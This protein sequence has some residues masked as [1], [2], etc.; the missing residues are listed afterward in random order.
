M[1]FDFVVLG[2][3][4]EEG[5]IASRDLLKSGYSVLLCGRNKLR[6]YSLLK[7]RHSRFVYVDLS[8]I[9]NTV[10]VLKDS[11]AK[12][13]LN[14]AELRWNLNAMQA[15]LKANMH[16]LDLGGL[17]EITK[18]Q[19]RL[20]SKFR[21]KNLL[22]LLGCG[23]TPGISNVMAAYS[24]ELL[25]RVD[26]IELGFSWDSNLKK[27]FLPYSFE[28]IVY[29]LTTPAIMLKDGKLGKAKVCE[30]LGSRKFENIGMQKTYCIVH[31]EV[32]TFYK[33]FRGKGLKN[34]HYGAGFPSHSFN[35]IETLINLGF[36]SNEPVTINGNPVRPVDFTREVLKK[37]EKPKGY[38]EV[39][40]VWVKVIGTKNSQWHVIEMGCYVES[41]KGWEDFGSNVG[42]GMTIS[43]M[44][45]ML[46]KG[47]IDGPEGIGVAAPEIVVH[48]QPFFHELMKRG[49]K[50]YLNKKRFV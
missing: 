16:Y 28:S 17:Q 14:C 45:Q 24:V 38:R 49:M 10:K 44:A 43:I 5:T 33:Y 36:G 20:D 48:P 22:A 39:E 15:C 41:L 23:S 26:S 32:F 19:Y 30:F 35:V 46:L 2:A 47:I 8:D 7:N 37:I 50:I 27:F 31:S 11:G 40:N 13:V 25:D 4:G 42:T 18:Q 34:V 3:T 6:V 1:K 29:E 21:E 12:I 9:E